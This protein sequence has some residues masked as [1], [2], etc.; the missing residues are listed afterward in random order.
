MLE[1]VPCCFHFQTRQLLIGG[2]QI[3]KQNSSV[4][5]PGPEA[6]ADGSSDD[7]KEWKCS[8]RNKT[9]CPCHGLESLD[10]TPAAPSDLLSTLLLAP[11]PSVCA[12]ATLVFLPFFKHAG[13]FLAAFAHADS[14]AWSSPP[15]RSSRGCMLN[16]TSISPPE[17]GLLSHQ[18]LSQEPI[19]V[20]PKL[21]GLWYSMCH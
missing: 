20:V 3:P 15:V 6:L 12:S 18:S 5:S 11:S 1:G 14:T 2:L 16:L 10:S 21:P 4:E 9:L 13:I 19:S 7:M 17:K 8:L